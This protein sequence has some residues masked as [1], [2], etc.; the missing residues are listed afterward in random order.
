MVLFIVVKGTEH[1]A[2]IEAQ[3]RGIELTVTG[4]SKNFTEVYCEAPMADLAKVIA[5]YTEDTGWGGT[6]PA[7]SCLW[8]AT[9]D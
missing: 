6:F 8:Y 7:G 3:R 4:T 9:R 5:W 1:N 2:E